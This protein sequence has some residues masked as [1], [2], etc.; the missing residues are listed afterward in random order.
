GSGKGRSGFIQIDRHRSR[1]GVSRRVDGDAGLRDLRAL[2]GYDDIRRNRVD[3]RQRIAAAEAYGD[4]AVVP[5]GSVGG[6]LDGWSD[7]RLG[8]IQLHDH[9]R[10]GAVAGEI[11]RAAIDALTAGFRRNDS[12]AADGVRVQA[13]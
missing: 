1:V 3:A 6:R 2:C 10:S 11:G 4:I 7:G 8:F 12:V 9:V 5:T 13:G